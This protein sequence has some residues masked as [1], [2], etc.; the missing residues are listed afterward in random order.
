LQYIRR[1]ARGQIR[2]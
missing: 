1:V 2:W